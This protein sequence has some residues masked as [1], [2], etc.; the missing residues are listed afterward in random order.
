MMCLSVLVA[1]LR[2]S[3]V[4]AALDCRHDMCEDEEA[5]SL[6]AVSPPAT[7]VSDRHADML[8]ARGTLTN[9][10]G[11]LGRHS[12]LL[13]EAGGHLHGGKGRAAFDSFLA[14]KCSHKSLDKSLHCKGYKN[15]FGALPLDSVPRDYQA[16]LA[17]LVATPPMRD[18]Q[19]RS[20]NL[21]ALS[22]QDDGY[23]QAFQAITP[24]PL[25]QL[26]GDRGYFESNFGGLSTY[27]VVKVLED[28]LQLY[29]LSRQPTESDPDAYLGSWFVNGDALSGGLNFSEFSNRVSITCWDYSMLERCTIRSGATMLV[30]TPAPRDTSAGRGCDIP[31]G[32]E[33]I[34]TM[35]VAD[36]GVSFYVL[37]ASKVASECCVVPLDKSDVGASITSS[38]CQ[39]V[40]LVSQG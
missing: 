24:L 37:N 14:C 7:N 27:S 11:L 5:A 1:W 3:A 38:K 20:L 16:V 10:R 4:L 35:Q 33:G 31:A 2:I 34:N 12:D 30:G 26:F 15:N 19:L 39:P 13:Q 22:V 8:H 21:E 32:S 18:E 36:R 29:R 17:G 28:D 40:S 25:N 6:L 9:P 23:P